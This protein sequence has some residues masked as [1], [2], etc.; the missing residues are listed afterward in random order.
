MSIAYLDVD[1]GDMLGIIRSDNLLA[2]LGL[3]LLESKYSNFLEQH[4]E[5]P[6][7]DH[8]FTELEKRCGE[9]IRVFNGIIY[10][11]PWD[12]YTINHYEIYRSSGSK[13]TKEEFIDALERFNNLWVPLKNLSAAAVKLME[14][15][16]DLNPPPEWAV[17]I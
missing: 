14:V 17:K 15:L 9:E 11:S 10:C 8:F 7:D 6:E 2:G 12:L 5:D 4:V 1:S 3:I 13:I 16:E